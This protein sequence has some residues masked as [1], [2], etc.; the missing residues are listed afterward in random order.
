MDLEVDWSQFAEN[1]LRNIFFY[2]KT[3]AGIKIARKIV[4]EIVDK[5]IA[6]NQIPK[7]VKLKNF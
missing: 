2:Y 6:L 4:N 5:T 7:S 3:K 1:K